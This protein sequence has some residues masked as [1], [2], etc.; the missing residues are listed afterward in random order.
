MLK[1][2]KEIYLYYRG[3]KHSYS[4]DWKTIYTKNC[5]TKREGVETAKYILNAFISDA[6]LFK[7]KIK[8]K[9]VKRT[10]RTWKERV[11]P[12]KYFITKKKKWK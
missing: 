5:I 6:G 4:K 7:N 10:L 3:Y 9:I 8:E 2:L 11:L 1:R 12:L